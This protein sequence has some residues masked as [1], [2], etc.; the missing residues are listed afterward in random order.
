[1]IIRE[2]TLNDL[3]TLLR[4]E[5]GIIEAERPMDPTIRN[6]QI[7][8]YDIAAMIDSPEHYVCVAELDGELVASA[9]AN[10]RQ[11]RPYLD[12][13]QYAYLGFMF[14]DPNHRGKGI[15]GKIME[16]LKKWCSANKLTELRLDVYSVNEAA[17]RAYVKAGFKPHLLNMRMRIED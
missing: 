14:V 4:F 15:N 6:G 7:N 12:H 8:Y 2:A 11:P 10:K 1:M 5:Q 17:I 3:P 16:A 13:K 9:Y